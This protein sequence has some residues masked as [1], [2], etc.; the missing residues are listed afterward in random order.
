MWGV[1]S[2]SNTQVNALT[3]EN[4]LP[5]IWSVACLVGKYD[6]TSTT[7]GSGTTVGQ[8]TDCFAEAWM[9]ATNSAK[10]QPTGA[11]GALMSYISQPWEPPMWG[12]DECVDILVESYNN[13]IKHT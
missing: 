12:Q 3:N 7:Y 1:A 6:N 5:F 13:N 8:T 2:Y 11:I 9:H 4:K 10:T